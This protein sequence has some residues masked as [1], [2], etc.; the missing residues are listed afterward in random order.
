MKSVTQTRFGA[1]AVK[2]RFSGYTTSRDLTGLAL[3]APAECQNE[4]VID[5][6]HWG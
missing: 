1:G 6:S 3:I 4:P 5:L 2:S